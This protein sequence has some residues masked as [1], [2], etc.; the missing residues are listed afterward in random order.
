MQITLLEKSQ[1][2]TNRLIQVS[3]VSDLYTPL[4][5]K[6]CTSHEMPMF[7]YVT[8]HIPIKHLSG[9]TLV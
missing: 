4:T 6:L 1:I 8:Q 5:P 9:V 7:S 3:W 2:H